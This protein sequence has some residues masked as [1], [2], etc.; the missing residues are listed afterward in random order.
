[1]S[2]ARPR[3]GRTTK[4]HG[5]LKAAMRHGFSAVTPEVAVI[6]S[7]LLI[8]LSFLVWHAWWLFLLVVW[9][10]KARA[11]RVRAALVHSPDA[12]CSGPMLP[13]IQEASWKL[14]LVQDEIDHAVLA[15][16]FFFMN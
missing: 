4:G 6:C 12:R 14:P 9:E 13:L 1:M 2:V 16:R 3:A 8:G 5:K 7:L 10:P 11:A 15:M